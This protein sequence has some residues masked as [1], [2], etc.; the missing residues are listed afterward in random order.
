MFRKMLEH[1]RKQSGWSVGRAACLLV[2]VLGLVAL[3]AGCDGSSNGDVEPSQPFL[4][5]KSPE[6]TPNIVREWLSAPTCEELIRALKR[7]GL[8]DLAATSVRGLLTTPPNQPAKDPEHPCADAA[9]PVETSRLFLEDGTVSS[10]DEFGRQV[11]FG[12]YGI[13]DRNT[14]GIAGFFVNYKID[15]RDNVIFRF[16][17]PERCKS[18]PGCRRRAAYVI[19]LL[20]PGKLWEQVS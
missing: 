3:T 11:G 19:G 20:Y 14:I 5:S 2:S 8:E 4:G 15:S 10:Y 1:D 12:Y 13:V 17:V 6:A 7:E 16:R 9:G 18:R